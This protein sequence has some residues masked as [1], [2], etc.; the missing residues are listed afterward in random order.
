MA[1][2]VRIEMNGPQT[3]L[4]YDDATNRFA[5]VDW[6]EFIESFNGFNLE[7]AR[8]FANIFYGTKDQI[9]DVE[10]Q[11]MNELILKEKGLPQKGDRWFKNMRVTEIP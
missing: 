3:L 8:E 2:L 7:V 4:S 6:L 11:F 1:S 5:Q 9:G 10:I